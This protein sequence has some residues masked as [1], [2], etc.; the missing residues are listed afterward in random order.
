[1]QLGRGVA[2]GSELVQAYDFVRV[3]LGHNF[4]QTRSG[5]LLQGALG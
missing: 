3:G 5:Y 2:H 1:M 4:V